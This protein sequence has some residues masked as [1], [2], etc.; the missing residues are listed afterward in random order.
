M[1]KLFKSINIW[2]FAV[3]M[4]LMKVLKR[5]WFF[6]P[7]G[8]FTWMLHTW[9][10]HTTQLVIMWST[11]TRPR[12][13]VDWNRCRRQTTFL[14]NRRVIWALNSWHAGCHTSGNNTR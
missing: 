7:R 1:L 8:I 12:E 9:A 13:V 10:Q 5:M 11:A 14:D 3:N 6:G 4:V 2:C